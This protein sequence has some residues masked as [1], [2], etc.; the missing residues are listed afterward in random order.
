[1]G[2]MLDFLARIADLLE[3]IADAGLGGSEPLRG[4]GPPVSGLGGTEAPAG[5]RYYDDDFDPPVPYEQMAADETD[6]QWVSLQ[7]GGQT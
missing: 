4:S 1:M 5:A 2:K 7:T 3:Q 6:P